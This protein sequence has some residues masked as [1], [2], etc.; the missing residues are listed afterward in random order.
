M[1]LKTIIYYALEGYQTAP[2]Q[3]EWSSMAVKW[4]IFAPMTIFRLPVIP[5]LKRRSLKESKSMALAQ[6]HLTL[7]VD[8][9]SLI[10]FLKRP[11]QNLLGKRMLSYSHLDIVLILE[12][13]QRSETKLSGHYK[14]S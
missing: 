4:L 7:S 13:F 9:Q 11:Y 5:W 1:S 2:K 6:G 8:T 10:N 3:Q 12:F 14:T